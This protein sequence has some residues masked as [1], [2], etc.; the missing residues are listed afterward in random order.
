MALLSK[1][2]DFKQ[3]ASRRMAEQWQV[4][5]LPSA[6]RRAK[7]AISGPVKMPSDPLEEQRGELQEMDRLIGS[8]MACAGALRSSIQQLFRRSLNLK[9]S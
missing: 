8:L 9:S 6:L 4:F 7:T 3:T 5:S 1:A 2:S